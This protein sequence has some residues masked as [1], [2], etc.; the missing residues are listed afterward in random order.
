[1][2]YLTQ[3]F[4]YQYRSNR[5]NL[6]IRSSFIARNFTLIYL[7]LSNSS[8]GYNLLAQTS[9]YN[10]LILKI[11]NTAFNSFTKVLFWKVKSLK[12]T[13]IGVNFPLSAHFTGINGL[14]KLFTKSDNPVLF[15]NLSGRRFDYPYF[16]SNIISL[17]PISGK[18][19]SYMLYKFL[20]M[21]LNVWF[22]WPKFYKITTNYTAINS[23]WLT[24]KFLNKY[25]FKLYNL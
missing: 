2:S 8:V 16:S 23:Y 6:R 7:L 9:A 20:R 12:Y 14:D 1:M 10:K 13:P 5:S 18:S 25:F 21:N 4:D 11:G 19:Y 24:L 17:T 15:P 22:T 3:N